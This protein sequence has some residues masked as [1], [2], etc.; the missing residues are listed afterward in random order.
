MGNDI[1]LSRLVGNTGSL[2]V[3]HVL[4]LGLGFFVNIWIARIR[5]PDRFS[6]YRYVYARAGLFAALCPLGL[7]RVVVR[8]LKDESARE[9]EILGRAF[10]LRPVGG[11]A[12]PVQAIAAF[13]VILPGGVEVRFFPA[14]AVTFKRR[15]H[16]TVH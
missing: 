16:A 12:P 7:D 10:V 5:D 9:A 11:V 6:V 14:V 2:L 3:D 1:R 8:D 13:A 15:A 4:R